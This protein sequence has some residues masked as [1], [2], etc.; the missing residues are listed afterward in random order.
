MSSSSVFKPL[1]QMAGL[2]RSYQALMTK[3]PWTLQIIT[4]GS[5]VGVG[6]VISQQL[7]ERRGL[8]NHSIRRTTKMMSIGFFFVGPVVGGWYKVLDKLVT[9]GTKSAA[10]KKMLADQDEADKGTQDR[11]SPHHRIT[12]KQQR[13]QRQPARPHL[14]RK[15]I[16]GLFLE[17]HFLNFLKPVRLV[18]SC[19][20][21]CFHL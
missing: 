16:L 3:H 14:S 17:T 5:L 20:C 13:F 18:R 7:I 10:L 1:C 8:A 9:G 4:A 19:V 2:W 6:D 11:P 15:E 21:G 12:P